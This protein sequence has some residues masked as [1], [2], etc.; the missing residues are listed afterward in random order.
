[1]RTSSHSRSARAPWWV[2][3]TLIFLFLGALTTLTMREE[4][5]VSP[6]PSPSPSW[7]LSPTW[8]DRILAWETIIL[9]IARQYQIDPNLIAALILLESGGR[10][11][12][13]S[14]SGAV[15]LMQIMPSDTHYKPWLFRGR[16]ARAELFHPEFNVRWGV[17]FLAVLY[18][19]N[20][21]NWPAALC[22]YYG[23]GGPSCV[24]SNK[25]MNLWQEA[26]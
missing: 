24:Y 14:R 25:I 19:R 6:S 3:I 13:V 21:D 17:H 15:G 26:K 2:L 9:P 8:P 18:H 4:L 7:V 23:S 22:E 11:N 16:P 10:P 1:M 20:N 5:T 12:A